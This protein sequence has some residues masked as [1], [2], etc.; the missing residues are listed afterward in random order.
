MGSSDVVIQ[1]FAGIRT[2]VEIETMATRKN[3]IGIGS[4]FQSQNHNISID[5]L[6]QLFMESE[7]ELDAKQLRK[8]NFEPRMNKSKLVARERER[9]RR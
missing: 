7:S 6:N 5:V 3:K 4:S 8:K 1:S 2:G 9:E